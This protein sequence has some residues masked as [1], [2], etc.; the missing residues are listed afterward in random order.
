MTFWAHYFRI[1]C[2]VTLF[3][4]KAFSAEESE[5]FFLEE[6][7]VFYDNEENFWLQKAKLGGILQYQMAW[8][9][10]SQ[11]SDFADEFRRLRLGGRLDF[12]RH[13]QLRGSWNISPYFD[14]VYESTSQIFV[15]WSPYGNS[16]KQMGKFSVSLGKMKPGFSREYG[17][18]AKKLRVLERSLLSAQIQ[19]RKSVGVRLSQTQGSWGYQV[20]LFSGEKRSNW[21]ELQNKWLF[22]A[23]LDWQPNEILEFQF[24]YMAAHAS[25]GRGTKPVHGVSLSGAVNEKYQAGRF[26]LEW[27]CLGLLHGANGGNACSFLITPRWQITKQWELIARYQFAFSRQE[28]GLRLNKRYQRIAAPRKSDQ[29]GSTY[30]ALYLGINYYHFGHKLKWMNGVEWARLGRRN[31][32]SL[33]S[34]SI[35]TGVR[36]YF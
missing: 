27:E 2:V 7:P 18:S 24:Q 25:R 8:I 28:A 36:I 31:S 13:F 17:T 12:A 11:E 19:P 3:L 14:P 22:L 20:S 29:Y 35:T 1:C 30:Q 5:N 6:L 34:I 23:E 26:A 10:S 4:N 32:N 15:Q 16:K 9:H 21:A 33:E